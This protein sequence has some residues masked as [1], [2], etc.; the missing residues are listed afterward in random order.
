MIRRAFLG[1]L[2]APLAGCG[3]SAPTKP[4]PVSKVDP[5]PEPAPEVFDKIAPMPR[6]VKSN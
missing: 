5:K 3:V 2:L 4:E 1:L 6:E